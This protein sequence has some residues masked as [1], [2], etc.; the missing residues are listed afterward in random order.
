VPSIAL[1]GGRRI[2]LSVK[3]LEAVHASH[4]MSSRVETSLMFKNRELKWLFLKK[5]YI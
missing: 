2:A 3:I 5:A 1:S 4:V